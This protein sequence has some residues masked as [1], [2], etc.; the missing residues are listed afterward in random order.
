M[1]LVPLSELKFLAALAASG[2][3]NFKSAALAPRPPSN[4][5]EPIGSAYCT[6]RKVGEFPIHVVEECRLSGTAQKKTL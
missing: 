3:E 5:R 4:L 6:V 1:I 2:I